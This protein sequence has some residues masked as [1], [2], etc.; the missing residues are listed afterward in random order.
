M[1]SQKKKIPARK[2]KQQQRQINM[3]TS[4][5]KGSI[6][7]ITINDS[8]VIDLGNCFSNQSMYSISGGSTDTICIDTNNFQTGSITSSG[9]LSWSQPY[10][11]YNFSD[12]LT[13][14]PTVNID[15]N[16]INVKEGG[17]IKIGGKSLVD[18]ISAIEDRLAILKPNLELEDKWE[19]LKDLRR[20]Y[21]ALERDILEK[22]KIMK[23]LKE[24]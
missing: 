13:T 5:T 8:T 3:D 12:N 22:E 11:N 4:Y 23:I 17:D 10:N 21:E 7:D 14:S 15:T 6:D 24:Q 1:K 16:G 20:Q 2:Q 9:T 19:Q 18:A